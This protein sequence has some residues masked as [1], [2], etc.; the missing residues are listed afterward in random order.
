MPS[1]ATPLLLIGNSN[2]RFSGVTSTMLQ[3]LPHQIKKIPLA[4]LAKHHLSPEVPTL[5]F[6]QLIT[7]HRR[8]PENEANFIFHARRNDEMIQAL[9]AKKLFRVPLKIIF[10]S[11]AQRHH[12]RFTRWLMQQMDGIITTC[13][14]AN[15][16]LKE[17]ADIIIPHGIDSE[18]YSPS[19]NRKEAWKKLNYGGTRGIGIFGRIRPSKGTDLFIEALIPLLKK[20]PDLTAIICGET[21]LKDQAYAAELQEKIKEAGLKKQCHWIGK[22]AFD[23]LPE[24][25]RSL[26][27]VVAASRNEGFGLTVLE[28]LSSATPV[29]ATEAGA[30]KDIVTN[31]KHGYCVPKENAAAMQEAIEKILNG[32]VETLGKQSRQHILDH[33][34]V[35]QEAESLVRFLQ[36][37]SKKK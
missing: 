7:T 29:V 28:A 35:E 24:L 11:T 27:V 32:D 30:W 23:H 21:K 37:Y 22:Q 9:L 8:P 12:S 13:N 1:T 15:S 36:T 18:R 26:S 3:V 14:A 19:E 5:S 4:V 10:T 31:G 17:K 6:R 33:Y 34:T 25:F 2:P 20:D 16:Y